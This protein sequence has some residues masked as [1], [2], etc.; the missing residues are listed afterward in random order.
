[1][2][3]LRRRRSPKVDITVTTSFTWSRTPSLDPAACSD[4][5]WHVEHV[6]NGRSL[7]SRVSPTLKLPVMVSPM[8]M[9]SLSVTVGLASEERAIS[10]L[11]RMVTQKDL[12]VQADTTEDRAAHSV[13]D[14]DFS[15]GVKSIYSKE[16]ASL[17]E[18][19]LS[20]VRATSEF[21][22]ASTQSPKET[23]HKLAHVA[24]SQR[25]PSFL[26]SNPWR[27]CDLQNTLPL[28]FTFPAKM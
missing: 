9:F 7:R 23:G 2:V 6:S 25:E 13:G 8:S 19:E 20:E 14:G 15:G 16:H 12:A 26:Q 17:R 3:P 18:R 27:R 28:L 21:A 1:M 11:Y 10:V 24:P 5:R 4:D 22:R